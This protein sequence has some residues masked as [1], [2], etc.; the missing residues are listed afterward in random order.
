MET[1]FE[2]HIILEIKNKK[3]E[4]IR[5]EEGRAIIKGDEICMVDQ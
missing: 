4:T 3:G 5:R 2:I 1:A